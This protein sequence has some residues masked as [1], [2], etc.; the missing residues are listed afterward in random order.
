MFKKVK[1][2]LL[3]NIEEIKTIIIALLTALLLITLLINYVYGVMLKDIVDKARDQE[4]T[5]EYMLYDMNY[6]SSVIERYMEAEELCMMSG[7]YEDEDVLV[8]CVIKNL[9]D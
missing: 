6:D 9:E 2:W 1:T 3:D 5:I 4:K 7:K 8:T